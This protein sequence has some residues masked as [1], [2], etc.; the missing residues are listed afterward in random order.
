MTTISRILSILKKVNPVISPILV[1]V[2]LFVCFNQY[3]ANQKLEHD[4]ETSK[5][6]ISMATKVLDRYKDAAGSE[7][8]VIDKETISKEQKNA[9]IKN[10]GFIDTVA[11]ALNIA[12]EKINELTRV[13]ATLLVANAKGTPVSPGVANSVIRYVD[14]YTKLSYNPV[15]TTFDFKYDVN[16]I[17]AGYSRKSG[18]LGLKNDDVIDLYSEDPRVTINGVERF[19]LEVPDPNFG[20]RGQIKT[21]YNFRSK[22]I[23]P[24]ATL[25]ANFKSYSLEANMFYNIKDKVWTPTIGIKKDL[26]HIK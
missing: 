10:T 11:R 24:A 23:T 6:R 9:L 20:L 8:L 25:E 5:E 26:F 3:Q 2:L 12:N 4:K 14:K 21:Q 22:S 17:T 7:H 19:Q 16:L 15:D 18:F 1:G 13:N